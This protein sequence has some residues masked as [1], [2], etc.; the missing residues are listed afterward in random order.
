MINLG[1]REQVIILILAAV[2]L[3]AA[4]YRF[5][6]HSKSNAELVKSQDTEQ[7]GKETG[8]V[9]HVD[10][11][12]QKPG[13]YKLPPGSRVNDAIEQATALPEADLS[14][15]NLAAPLKDGQKLTVAAKA[16]KAAP[17]QSVS[18]AAG[19]GGQT[20]AG[21]N[22]GV[23]TAKIS[24]GSSVKSAGIINI[25]TA[26]ESELDRLPGIGPTLASRIVQYRQTNGNFHS[27][28]DLKNVPGIGDKKFADLQ[29]L[30]TV[31]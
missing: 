27:I 19:G 1:R 16:D 14:S 12:V 20:A 2:V 31:Q 26:S 28:E 22:P 17:G 4:G 11:A 10:G 7:G 24:T 29:Q 15:L 23:P 6:S 5:A 13:V 30:I 8:P 21:A 9:V 3:F 18:P 25:N